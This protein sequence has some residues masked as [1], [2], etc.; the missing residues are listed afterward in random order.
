MTRYKVCSPLSRQQGKY[1][2]DHTGIVSAPET[3][4]PHPKKMK[5]NIQIS[6]KASPR[7]KLTFDCYHATEEVRRSVGGTNGATISKFEIKLPFYV[8]YASRILQR[9]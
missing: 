8:A 5:K 1:A 6:T 3:M 9:I 2:L 7:I 4:L